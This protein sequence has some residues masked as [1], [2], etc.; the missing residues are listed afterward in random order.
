MIVHKSTCGMCKPGKRFKR[1]NTKLKGIILDAIYGGELSANL[2]KSYE[3]QNK[4][5]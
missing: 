4:F 5:N 3:K 1:N 2:I